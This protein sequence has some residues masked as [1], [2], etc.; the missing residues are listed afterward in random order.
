MSYARRPHSML[1]LLPA[2]SV[3]VL[4]RVSSKIDGHSLHLD[5]ESLQTKLLPQLICSK[6]VFAII[7][8]G[9]EAHVCEIKNQ[10]LDQTARKR[11]DLLQLSND[12]LLEITLLDLVALDIVVAIKLV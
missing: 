6:Y 4:A 12:T 11:T 9:P 5:S 3:K 2:A 8:A 1:D 10:L 7:L